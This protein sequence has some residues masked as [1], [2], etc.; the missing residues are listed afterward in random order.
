MSHPVFGQVEVDGQRLRCGAGVRLKAIAVEARRYGVG[1]LEFLEGIPGSL[2]GGLRMNAGAM[3]SCMFSMVESVRGM[4]RLGKVLEIP[5]SDLPVVYRSCPW[6]ESHV[7]LGAVL[8]GKASTA[9]AVAGVMK[10]Y[11]AKR[12]ESQPAQS[13]AGCIFKNPAE[14][15]AGKLIDELGLKGMRVGAARVSDVHG[16]FIINEGG[17]T[18]RDVLELIE[19][20]R[21]QARAQRRIELQTEVEIVGE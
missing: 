18:A 8:R 15:P 16:N 1:G 12:W 21:A 7:A 11:S 5:A 13:S 19:K 14:I 20:V 4:D 17:A 2:G 9:E 3:G 6:F 10:G